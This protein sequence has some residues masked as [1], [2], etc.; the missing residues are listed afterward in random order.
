MYSCASAIFI[1]GRSAR[2]ET[3]VQYC[4]SLLS[5][6]SSMAIIVPRYAATYL[7]CMLSILLTKEMASD[8]VNSLAKLRISTSLSPPRPNLSDSAVIINFS[9]SCTFPSAEAITTANLTIAAY[10]KR[11][12]DRCIFPIFFY[13]NPCRAQLLSLSCALVSRIN[14][15]KRGA[16]CHF[17]YGG[18]ENH[19]EIR[20]CNKPTLYK[21]RAI[22]LIL[23]FRGISQV[24]IHR[25]SIT[26][27]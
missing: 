22:T 7:L 1:V 2:V 13:T 16:V 25:T 9:L 20:R 23:Y 26:L 10:S 21:R 12:N 24:P 8:G 17:L 11:L 4:I 19:L 18:P 6:S 14:N 5:I 15:K 27:R 3:S